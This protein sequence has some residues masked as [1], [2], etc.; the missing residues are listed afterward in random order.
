MPEINANSKPVV[1]IGD[2]VEH[3]LSPAMHNAAI[4]ALG[5]D[6]VYVALKTDKS[7]LPHVLRALEAVGVAGNVTVPHKVSV[8]NLL[9]RVT[10]LAKELGAVNT[11]WPE[12]GRL[13]GDNTDVRGLLDALGPLDPEG[14]WLVSGT[15]GA[16]RAVA[17][18]A[19]ESGVLLL[20]QSRDRERAAGFAAWAAE[21]G[22]DSR[23]DDGTPARTALN[24]T[25]LGLGSADG[26]P[27]LEERLNG[28]RAAFDLVYAKGGTRW[29]RWCRE[30]GIRAEDGRSMLVAQGGHSFERFFPGEAAPLE[31]MN[32]AVNK[33]LVG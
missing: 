33:E 30:R 16:A 2:P 31:V 32:A 13:V 10:S 6:A 28:C 21:M 22:V 12:G 1:L 26:L 8:A 25:P 3:S 5:L 18:A 15:G 20:V 27:F 9:I 23:A 17:V 24:A 4:T 29:V 11:F 19:R 14:P 7:A